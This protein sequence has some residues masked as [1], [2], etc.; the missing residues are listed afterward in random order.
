MNAFVINSN[1][2]QLLPTSGLKVNMKLKLLP[3]FVLSA[4]KKSLWSNSFFLVMSPFASKHFYFAVNIH[5]SQFNQFLWHNTY[6]PFYVS[7][8][9]ISD[10]Q[11]ESWF[12]TASHVE[13][14]TFTHFMSILQIWCFILSFCIIYILFVW[15]FF[16]KHVCPYL[17]PSDLASFGLDGVH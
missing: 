6:F 4:L 15:L 5:F 9:S 10:P 7:S 2:F 11:S 13:F 17:C 12:W 16:S 3:A 1:F 8:N 14:E